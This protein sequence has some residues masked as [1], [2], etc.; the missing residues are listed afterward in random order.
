M[1]TTYREII[2]LLNMPG[3]TVRIVAKKLSIGEDRLRALLKDAGYSF[4]RSI[5]KWRYTGEGQAPDDEFLLKPSEEEA[6]I[7]SSTQS[8]KEQV[9]PATF[10][11]E[12][13][14]AIQIIVQEC[15]AKANINNTSQAKSLSEHI[16]A[17]PRGGKRRATFVYEDS[18]LEQFE[19]LADETRYEK[20]ALMTLATSILVKMFKK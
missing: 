16:E 11:P 10:T 8:T 13:V 14:A 17:L 20:S 4:D 3:A 1:N 15:L 9:A 7:L 2:E 5:R 18:V 19:E 12:Q 6:E